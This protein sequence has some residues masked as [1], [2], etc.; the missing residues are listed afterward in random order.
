MKTE[1]RAVLV[2]VGGTLWSELSLPRDPNGMAE[3]AEYSVLNPSDRHRAVWEQ[4]LVATGVP[5]ERVAN[6]CTQLNIALRP[7]VTSAQFDVWHAIGVASRAASVV[8]IDGDRIRRACCLPAQDFTFLLPGAPDLLAAL[9]HRGVRVVI[10]SNALWRDE[11]DYWADL[12]AFGIEALVDAVVSSVD[13]R[14]RKPSDRFYDAVLKQ[15][16]FPPENCLMIGNSETLDVVPSKARG[17]SAIRVAIEEPRPSASI[18]DAVYES[19]EEVMSCEFL[20]PRS[21]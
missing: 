17:M 9:R 7:A 15:A 2:D 1:L 11:A 10:A 16:G 3:K 20:S 13:V 18:A 4:R 14:W 12:R 19:L 8:G 5:A 6:L 21:G